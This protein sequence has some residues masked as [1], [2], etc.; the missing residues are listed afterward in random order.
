M[1]FGPD[2]V[3]DLHEEV[4]LYGARNVLAARRVASLAD[5]AVSAVPA[6]VLTEQVTDAMGV[7]GHQQR[8][9]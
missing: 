6:V 5:Q 7:G 2:A 4:H 9:R 1:P 3:P 8:T